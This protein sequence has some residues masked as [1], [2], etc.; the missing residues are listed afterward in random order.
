MRC[1]ADVRAMGVSVVVGLEKVEKSPFVDVADA[2][3]VVL[4]RIYRAGA[5]ANGR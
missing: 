3:E 2:E 4:D 1:L 5:S